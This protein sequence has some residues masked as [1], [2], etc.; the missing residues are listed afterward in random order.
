MKV[1]II[2]EGPGDLKAL[3]CLASK[4]GALFELEIFAPNPIKSG[5]FHV[6]RRDGQLER[7]VHM[8]ARRPGIERILVVA[9]LDDGCAAEQ[10]RALIERAEAAARPY[11]IPIDVCFCIREYECWFL[12]VIQELSIAAESIEWAKIEEQKD[13][14]SKRDAKG[15]LNSL[16]NTHY[17][18][19]THQLI[20]T[21]KLDLFNLY[22]RSRSFRKF[23][24]GITGFSYGDLD[25][26]FSAIG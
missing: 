25:T 11:G 18:E 7:F 1:A 3:P 20:L 9:D 5:G 13:P 2:A 21:Q 23:V 26:Y 24:K 15:I 10:Y 16:M 12:E 22:N 6:L 4:T 14:Q 17:K 8:A 19:Q